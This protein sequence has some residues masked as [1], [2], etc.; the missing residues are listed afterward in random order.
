V[1]K[2]ALREEARA[3]RRAL[4]ASERAA[5]SERIAQHALGLPELGKARAV[6]CYAS[7]GSEV[8]TSLL[9]RGLLARGVLVAVPT[10][11]GETLR[12]VRL[13]HPW[14]L[15]PGPR[16]VPVPRQPWTDVDADALDVVFVPGLLFGRDGARLGQG[17]GHFD[18]FLAAHPRTLR[19]GLAF[20]AQVVDRIEASEPHDQGMDALVTEEARLRIGR[21][22]PT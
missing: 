10:I 22:A 21:P 17:G 2:A 18:R 20:A 15:V 12:F 11:A 14:A 8:D 6:G 16:Q 1:D 9:L 19:V 3:R 5:W 13:D 7:T 4:P